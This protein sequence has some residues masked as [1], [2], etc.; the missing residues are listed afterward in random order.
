[1]PVFHTTESDTN[2]TRMSRA[3]R[4]LQCALGNLC[5]GEL[6]SE[7]FERFEREAHAL[8][9][10]AECEVLGGQLESLDVDLAYVSIDARRHHRLFRSRQTYMSAV[11]PVTVERTLYRAGKGRSVVPMELRGGIVEGHW[12]TLAARQASYLVSELTPQAC[13]DTLRELGNM[14]PSKSSVDRLPK[15]LSARW[16]GGREGFE[17]SLREGSSVPEEAVSVA[18]SLD[19]VMV[20]MKD[21]QREAKRARSRAVG[22][23]TKG[24]AGYQEASCATLSFYDAEG[25]RLATTRMG[26][27][28]ESK[29]ATLKS[30]LAGEVH[31]ALGQRPDLTVVKVADGARDNWTYLDA[32]VPDGTVVVDFYHAAEQLKAAL[33]AAYGQGS[34]KGLAQFNK[35][36]HV[37]LEDEDGVEKVIRALVYLRNKHRRRQRIGEVLRYLR[38]NRHRMRYAQIR[39][40][41]LPIGSGVVEAACKTLATQR[42]KRSGMRWRNEGGQAILT[43]RALVQSERFDH[44]W[45]MLSDTYRKDVELPDNVVELRPRR[46]A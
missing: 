26:R 28:P 45:L 22:K 38:R 29:K 15:R 10:E 9:K 1:M 21:G 12:T 36:R 13:E 7:D 4:T 25:K 37:L 24:P 39:A 14:Q 42:L 33:D 34:A 44:A 23:Q 40:Q 27:M 3:L 16:E 32:L 8:F 30:M 46:A 18:V 2:T 20:P 41:H 35:L 6:A 19:G 11:G 31:A 43:L 17:A 5:E